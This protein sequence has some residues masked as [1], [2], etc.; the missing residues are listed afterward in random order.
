M[1]K[2]TSEEM[3]N[4]QKKDPSLAKY[5]SEIGKVTRKA[6]GA[7]TYE[8]FMN[9]GFLFRKCVS[10]SEKRTLQLVLPEK[11]RMA[12]P[13]NA[14]RWDYVGTSRRKKIQLA[15]CARRFSDQV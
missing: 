5:F 15:W 1:L 13:G 6:K 11:F 7:V 12:V 2:V 3:A 10:G 9:Q 8:Y 14:P 4:A